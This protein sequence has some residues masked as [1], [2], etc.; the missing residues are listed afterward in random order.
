MFNDLTKV[1]VRKLKSGFLFILP[2]I[3]LTLTSCIPQKRILILQDK[4]G[5][6]T[7]SGEF[8]NL[9][10]Q[11]KIRP[12]DELFIRVEG[13]DDKTATFFSTGTGNIGQQMQGGMYYTSNTVNDKGLLNYPGFG[14]I[15]VAGMGIFDIERILQDSLRNYVN[16]GSLSVKMANFRVGVLGEVKAPGTLNIQD[17]YAT[18]FD[19]IAMAGDLTPYGNRN[20]ITIIRITDQGTKYQEVDITDRNILSSPY[21]YIYPG[22]VV[23]VPQM[24]SKAFGLASFQLGNW[25]SLMGTLISTTTMILFFVNQEK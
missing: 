18:I 14:D 24:A 12:G 16:F 23:Y 21:Y 13:L 22:D 7:S 15:P 20:K 5:N 3:F 8:N 19:V 17:E 2:L 6:N 1:R 9:Q 10:H 11:Y 4:S 25:L